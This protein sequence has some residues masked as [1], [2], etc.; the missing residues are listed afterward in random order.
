[1]NNTL[2]VSPS[3]ANIGSKYHYLGNQRAHQLFFYCGVHWAF[4][5]AGLYCKELGY[6]TLLPWCWEGKI[7]NFDGYCRLWAT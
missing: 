4:Q 2:T 7:K 1:M 5:E 6:R 3:R